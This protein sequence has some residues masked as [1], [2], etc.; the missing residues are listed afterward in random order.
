MDFNISFKLS[1][2]AIIISK[3]KKTVEQKNLNNTNVINLKELKF[4]CSYILENKELVSSFLNVTILKKNIN[5]VVISSNDIADISLEL[6]NTWEHIKKIIFKEDKEINMDIFLK[7]IDNH[8]IEEIELYSMSKYLIE[9]LD[10]NKNLI[11]KTRSQ[12]EKK[13]S[14]MIINSLNSFSDIYYKKYIIVSENDDLEDIRTFINLNDKL[15]TV[16]IMKYSNELLTTILDELIS[17][18]KKNIRIEI[19]EKNN[20]LKTIFNSVNYLKKVNK[21]YLEENNIAFK[22]N[23]SDAYKKKN[24]FKEI[25]FKMFTTIIVFIMITAAVT[26]ML[27]YYAQFKDNET[28]EKELVDINK[29]IDDASSNNNL[30]ENDRD[31]DYIDNREETITTTKK[32][33]SSYSNAYYTNYKQVFN[34]LMKKNDDTVGYLMVNNT[35]INYPIV[36]AS[37]NSYYLNRD[38]NKRKNSMGWIFMDYRNNPT[39]LDKN[40]IIYGHNIKQGIM[41]GTLKYAL[42]SSWYRKESNQIITFN[43]PTKNMK[44]HIFSIYKIPATEDYLK[45]EF[46][47]D[48]EYMNFVNMLKSRSLYDFNVKIDASSKILTLSTC[49]SHTTRHV[50]HAVLI[51]EEGIKNQE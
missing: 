48:D 38:F 22:L 40:T 33:G 17:N 29:I 36:Q 6:V 15:K 31:I 1:S 3:M 46:A 30:D 26:L 10:V 12:I 25:N 32:V 16:K 43:T 14:F 45:T 49:F 37:T 5:T 13:S 8:Y 2:N 44:W 24:L 4:S 20:D 11:V 7:L 18:K 9:R 34:E 39:N 41:F 47:N 21:D 23:Y 51:E 50:V 42:N 27:D 28:V 19:E 35:K